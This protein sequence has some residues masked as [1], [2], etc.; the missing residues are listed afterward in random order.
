MRASFR[1]E[2]IVRKRDGVGENRVDGFLYPVQVRPFGDLRSRRDPH[3]GLPASASSSVTFLDG[4]SRV[5]GLISSSVAGTFPL[6]VVA[7]FS[8][9]R[10]ERCPGCVLVPPGSIRTAC[11]DPGWLDRSLGRAL[12]SRS[13]R[14]FAGRCG[15][16]E[17]AG[18][19]IVGGVVVVLCRPVELAGG[20][21]AV[22]AEES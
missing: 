2:L 14:E 4:V 12:L 17:P 1:G 21:P 13:Y 10:P 19:G 3:E 8:Y 5:L 15:R 20:G 18:P 6:S 22:S 7:G 11:F 9:S 16:A